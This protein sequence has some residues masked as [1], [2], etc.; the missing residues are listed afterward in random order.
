M[1]KVNWKQRLVQVAWLLAGIGTVVLLGAAMQQKNRKECTDIRIEITGA[2]QHM[3]IDEKDI[4]DMLQRNGPVNGTPVAALNLRAMETV[5]E[6]DPWVKQAEMFFDNQQVLQVR[7]EERQPVARVFTIQGH[8]FYLD[9]G[10]MRLPLSEKLSARVPMFTNFP[11]DRKLLSKPDSTLLRNV[12]KLGGYILADSFW[13][14]QVA[15]VDITLQANFELVPVVGDHVVSLGSADELDDK[16]NRLYTFY[17]QAWL[18]NGIN[19]YDRLDLRF[20]SQ[21]VA[22]KRNDAKPVSVVKPLVKEPVKTKTINTINNKTNNNSLTKKRAAS[23]KK[24]NKQLKQIRYES[25]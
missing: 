7:I 8:S 17:K 9:S 4:M 23:H 15:Q 19:T 5:I 2:E 11:S 13:L 3:F 20:N 22:R 1:Q 10:A 12:V 18:Q 21:V 16:F 6:K 25:Q 24:N 14:A